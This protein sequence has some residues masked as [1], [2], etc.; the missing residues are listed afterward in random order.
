MSRDWH[1]ASKAIQ[2][3][4]A[5]Q[6]PIKSEG[7]SPYETHYVSQP[8]IIKRRSSTAPNLNGWKRPLAQLNR[9]R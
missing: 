1:T 6:H 7:M 4:A 3:L 8:R 9:S 2:R 5:G